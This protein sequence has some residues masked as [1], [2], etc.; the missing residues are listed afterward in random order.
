[1]PLPAD[2]KIIDLSNRLLE[3][4]QALFGA[5]PGFR[6]A[7]AK[8]IMLQGS[9]APTPD[10]VAL[11]KAAHFN[12]PSTQV[13]VRFSNSTGVPVIP[14]NDPNADPRG[15]AVRFHLAEHVHTDIV[16]HSTNAFPARTGDDFLEFL[17]AVVATD[18]AHISG[19]PL[20]KYLGTHPAALAFVQAPKPPASSFARET[21]FGLNAMRFISKEGR[22]RYGRYRIVP[23][24]GNEH[25]D[26]AAAAAKGPNYLFDELEARIANGPVRLQVVAQMAEDGDTVNDVTV[27]WP[28]TRK[29]LELGIISL[30][31]PV[32][33]Q[34]HEQKE[35]IFDPIPRLEGIEPSDDPLFELRAAIYLISGRRRRLAPDV[36]SAA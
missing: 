25:L 18:M 22:I 5:H 10:A 23:Q 7:H 17:T 8:G 15:C 11:S 31:E 26:P 12:R 24:A 21:Y 6:P 13:T 29:F 1:M 32:L 3:K 16:A 33:D 4:F 27:Q 2:P 36:S 30:T 34:A 14:D 20:E 35:I 9:F 19:S 28:D